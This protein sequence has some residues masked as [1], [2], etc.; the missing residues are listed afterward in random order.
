M[1]KCSAYALVPR[2]RARTAREG[3]KRQAGGWRREI[4][5]LPAFC[6]DE[7][8]LQSSVTGAQ[9]SAKN[10]GGTQRTE[11]K[12]ERVHFSQSGVYVPLLYLV[13]PFNSDLFSFLFFR[14]TFTSFGPARPCCRD[15]GRTQDI[16][17]WAWTWVW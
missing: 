12:I 2:H 3:Q 13:L 4:T 6:F 9:K 5:S 17:A 11:E 16:Q 7:I 1:H 8:R 10:P 15:Q 14:R